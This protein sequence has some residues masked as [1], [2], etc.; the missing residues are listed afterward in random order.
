MGPAIPSN[1]RYQILWEKN[2]TK[3]ATNAMAAKIGRSVLMK[4]PSYWAKN[5]IP[6]A[7]PK[8]PSAGKHDAQ[9]IA[10]TNTP[11][12]PVLSKNR[13]INTIPTP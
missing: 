8:E 12:T 6:N 4:T 9:P 7:A 10:A 5:P 3:F 13:L 1:V 2:D 11:R